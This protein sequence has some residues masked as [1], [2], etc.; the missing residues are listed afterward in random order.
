[1]INNWSIRWWPCNV[2]PCTNKFQTKLWSYETSTTAVCNNKVCNV[3]ILFWLG[4]FYLHLLVCT[5]IQ[6][7]LNFIVLVASSVAVKMQSLRCNYEN[8]EL[9]G[10]FE[11]LCWL[12]LWVV[13]RT[14]VG[15]TWISNPLVWEM[16]PFPQFPFKDF[17]L[18][19]Q[20]IQ[21]TFWTCHTVTYLPYSI[22][23]GQKN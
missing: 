14:A 22:N 4:Y 5:T 6:L 23:L 1:M 21:A 13:A 17:K 11:L 12:A 3:G 15:V 2:P 16:E 8:L 10:W 9:C 18:W 19:K 20:N 7:D